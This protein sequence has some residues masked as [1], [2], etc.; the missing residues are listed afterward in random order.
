M[1]LALLLLFV[2]WVLARIAASMVFR[3]LK[4]TTWDDWIAEKLGLNVLLEGR[5]GEDQIERF[6]ANF[7]YYTL[8]ALVVVGALQTVGLTQVAA[9]IQSVVDSLAQAL[10]QV[11]KAGLILAAAWAGGSI[12]RIVI[13]RALDGAGIDERFAELSHVDDDEETAS[14]D[15]E[16]LPSFS[17]NVGNVVFWLAM[18]VAS[19]VLLRP[20]RSGRSPTHCATRWTRSSASCPI[21]A[22]LPC[23]CL[24]AS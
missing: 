18:L 22:L 20:C 4:R 13:S 8:L 23:S 21:W 12:L 9:P 7:T 16:P 14:T 17:E 3:A 15:A 6:F 1:G 11:L 24:L 19:Q 5:D 2:G 10:P